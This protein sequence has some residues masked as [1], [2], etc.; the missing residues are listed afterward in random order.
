VRHWISHALGEPHAAPALFSLPAPGRVLVSG[1][2]GT[3][4]VSA[5]GSARRLGSWRQ[6]SWSPRG[7]YAA[8]VGHGELAAVDPR[9]TPS[10]T[11]ARPAVRA[12]S[13]DPPTGY[14]IA[15]LSGAQL[16]VVAGDGTGD[17]LV[18]N[19]VAPVAP[20]WRPGHAYELA[21]LT[22]D[23]S[24]L[25]RDGDTDRLVWHAHTIGI[26]ALAWSS[27][28]DRLLALGRDHAT[29]YGPNGRVLTTFAAPAGSPILDGSLSPNGTRLALVEGGQSGAV[30][31]T[32]LDAHGRTN[33]RVLSG[34]GLRQLTWSPDSHWLL[35]S[36]PAA[37]Q[38]VFI[39]VAG[40]PRIAAVSHI[41]RQ[42]GS[43]GTTRGFPRIEGWC[44]TTSGLAG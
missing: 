8:V 32:S 22:P 38:W 9:G 2:G 3:W 44:C 14:R 35:V 27:D 21:Y 33:R 28:G 43:T 1:S 15:Y 34:A 37:D 18:A 24:L 31:L 23:G 6:A 36:W 29:V 16:R 30:T 10:W 5:D 26:R 13:W 25:V 42:F 11:L 20:A 4:I 17:H 19:A 39:R 12:P 7:L 41:G 40:T